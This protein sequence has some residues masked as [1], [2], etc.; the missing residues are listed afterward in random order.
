MFC[1]IYNVHAIKVNNRFLKAK[2][3][4]TL[5]LM[6]HHFLT[7][8]YLLFFSDSGEYKNEMARF[9][10][11]M[12]KI[13]VETPEDADAVLDESVSSL[14]LNDTNS[15]TG[16]VIH[17][18]SEKGSLTRKDGKVISANVSKPETVLEV[19][20][21]LAVTEEVTV[22]VETLPPPPEFDDKGDKEVENTQEEEKEEKEEFFTETIEEIVIPLTPVPSTEID[23]SVDKEIPTSNSG[24]FLAQPVVI[25][26]RNVSI[27]DVEPIP[28][29]K[30]PNRIELKAE[31]PKEK[32]E[33]VLTLDDLS[34]VSF[35]P[36]PK[37]KLAPKPKSPNF[38]LVVKET[39]PVVSSTSNLV[40]ESR[41]DRPPPSQ[42]Y[43]DKPVS[44]VSFRPKAESETDS[45]LEDKSITLLNMPVMRQTRGQLVHTFSDD[46]PSDTGSDLAVSRATP[47]SHSNS[48][49]SSRKSS[50]GGLRDEDNSKFSDNDSRSSELLDNSVMERPVSRG[51]QHR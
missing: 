34:S 2:I 42:L 51:S 40:F 28:E 27:P 32:E 5:Y 45:M 49:N 29:S 24:V 39:A 37:P 3:N 9:V 44:H 46:S 22:P 4:E 10:E 23:N 1:L 35:L 47:S 31:P 7:N 30:P 13:A 48:L 12:T 14:S 43:S 18:G 50:V 33:F 38:N 19:T 17:H 36:P 26:P 41:S 15:D 25:T 8:I 16:S 20:T 6:I 11:R 21:D